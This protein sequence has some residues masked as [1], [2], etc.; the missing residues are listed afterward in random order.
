MKK[1]EIE[2]KHD[3]GSFK[4]TVTARNIEAAQKMVMNAENC[5]P[6]ALGSWRVVPTARQIAKTKRLMSGL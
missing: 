4:I 6:S 3:N 1:Y 5:P 2:V